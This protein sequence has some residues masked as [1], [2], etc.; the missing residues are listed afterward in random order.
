MIYDPLS[1]IRRR[2]DGSYVTARSRTDHNRLIRVLSIAIGPAFVVAA[3]QGEVMRP[4]TYE[5]HFWVKV[6]RMWAKV[7]GL[8]RW[9]PGHDKI[10]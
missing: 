5:R 8:G 4:P 1:T 2:D 6:A 10:D 9:F 3:V 7:L